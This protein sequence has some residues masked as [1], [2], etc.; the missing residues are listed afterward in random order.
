MRIIFDGFGVHSLKALHEEAIKGRVT[1]IDAAVAFAG[2]EPQLFR[3]RPFGNLSIT[4]LGRIDGVSPKL[5]RRLLSNP[6]VRCRL[7]TMRSGRITTVMRTS[8]RRR[9]PVSRSM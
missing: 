4:F 1:R 3:T 6:A 2:D 5:L 7:V 9:V 8:T